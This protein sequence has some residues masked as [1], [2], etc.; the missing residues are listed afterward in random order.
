MRKD[1]QLVYSTEI[2]RIKPQDDQSAS[3]QSDGIV[4]IRRETKG[5]KGKGVT[6]LSGFDLDSSALKQLAKQLK[7][8]CSTGGSI[9]NG[10]IEVQGDHRDKLKTEL[11]KLNFKVKL[12]GG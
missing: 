12:V 3:P 2:G 1:S 11:E 7:Q 4:R 5:R 6:T 8:L 10:V 9:K